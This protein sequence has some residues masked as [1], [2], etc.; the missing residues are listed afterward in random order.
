MA[1]KSS[2]PEPLT[3]D[4]LEQEK[5]RQMG[6]AA[7]EFARKRQRENPRSEF[8]GPEHVRLSDVDE[9][10]IML[11]AIR[12]F[13]LWILS[14]A[15]TIMIAGFGYWAA[16]PLAVIAVLLCGIWVTLI[17]ILGT[18]SKQARGRH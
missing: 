18:I 9:V 2:K 4:E 7:R 14:L 13:V 17:R 3:F 11:D 10:K 6:G 1:D 16:G 5:L 8:S 15:A 12:Q